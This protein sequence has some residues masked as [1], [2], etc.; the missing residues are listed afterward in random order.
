[1][2]LFDLKQKAEELKEEIWSYMD[3]QKK[4]H[5][6]LKEAVNEMLDLIDE[7]DLP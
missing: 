2:T 1:M 4:E 7:L 6:G 3:C 5:A